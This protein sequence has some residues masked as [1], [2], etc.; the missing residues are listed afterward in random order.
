MAVSKSYSRERKYHYRLLNGN[1][2][3]K[4]FSTIFKKLPTYFTSKTHYWPC[5]HLVF[6]KIFPNMSHLDT[7]IQRILIPSLSSEQFQS[8]T[9]FPPIS[10]LG[11]KIYT[12]KIITPS[13]FVPSDGSSSKRI[14]LILFPS[15][16]LPFSDS[17]THLLYHKLKR[18]AVC[19]SGK[20]SKKIILVIRGFLLSICKIH[21]N[22]VEWYVP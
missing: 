17:A 20:S 2:E 19:L 16:T 4:L 10:S 8:F 3:W 22:I 11:E 12:I 6:I 7:K 9:K 5:L 18:I 15:N 13:V 1:R 14:L 21:T